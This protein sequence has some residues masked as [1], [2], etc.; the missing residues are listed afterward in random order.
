MIKTYLDNN[1]KSFFF[2]TNETVCLNKGYI[3]KDLCGNLFNT[4]RQFP[5]LCGGVA[6]SP[7][8]PECVN[9]YNVTAYSSI[10]DDTDLGTLGRIEFPLKD[11]NWDNI[12]QYMAVP[13]WTKKNKLYNIDKRIN[14]LKRV[15]KYRNNSRAAGGDGTWENPITGAVWNHCQINKKNIKICKSTDKIVPHLL[16]WEQLGNIYWIPNIRS[17]III[18]DEVGD[19]PSCK[20]KGSHIDIWVGTSNYLPATEGNIQC[21]HRTDPITYYPTIDGKTVCISTTPWTASLNDS[22]WNEYY[23]TFKKTV[24]TYKPSEKNK[25]YKYIYNQFSL[26]DQMTY[27]GEK[28]NVP[29]NIYLANNKFLPDTSINS[30]YGSFGTPIIQYGYEKW[31]TSNN[32]NPNFKPMRHDW[33]K[34]KDLSPYPTDNEIANYLSKITYGDNIYDRLAPLRPCLNSKAGYFCD[35]DSDCQNTKITSYPPNST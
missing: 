25:I 18:E 34:C 14:N 1:N 16:F 5:P 20:N 4:K 17:Y 11:D 6:A 35:T 12:K 33:G 3:Y 2:N 7:E 9:L 15:H 8:S 26:M 28:D 27:N 24:N 10:F 29:L 13:K 19:C 22:S 30:P 31:D 21:T 23:E 32:N